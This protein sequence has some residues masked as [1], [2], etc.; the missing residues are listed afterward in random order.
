MSQSVFTKLLVWNVELS[1][2]GTKSYER[3]APRSSDWPGSVAA[4]GSAHGSRAGPEPRARRHLRLAESSRRRARRM[5]EDLRVGGRL[6]DA[7][8][9][10]RLSGRAR[11]RHEH[12]A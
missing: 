6:R 10:V 4:G 2:T 11:R 9:H 3:R 8:R 1:D 12:G 5:A 7:D